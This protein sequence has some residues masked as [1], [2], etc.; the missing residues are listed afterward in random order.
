VA[1]TARG[2]VADSGYRVV[3]VIG[4]LDILTIAHLERDIHTLTIAGEVDL[5][6]DLS[7]VRLCD[8][9]AMG[10]LIRA[11][12]HCRAL[13]GSLRLAAPT[14]IV[15]TAFQIVALDKD[16]PIYQTVEAARITSANDSAPPGLPCGE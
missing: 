14:G 2:S 7:Q 16:L 10:G 4:E 13:G 8:A 3:A 11:S 5:I 6:L 12:K 9:A 15:A 1:D